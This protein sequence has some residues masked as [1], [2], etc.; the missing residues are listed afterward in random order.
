[1]RIFHSKKQLA[2]FFMPGF[3]LGIIYMNF[4]ADKYMAEPGI[5]NEYFLNQF[6]T[7]YIDAK[8]YIWY[9]LK[10]RVLPIVILYALSNTRASKLSA[11]LYVLW[12]GITG[13]ILVTSAVDSLGLKGS[14][15]CMTG[16]FPQFAFY[17]PA[18]M[19]LLWYCY[20]APGNS[21]NRQ[22]TIFVILCMAVGI[23]SELYINPVFVKAFLSVL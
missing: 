6:Q 17:I 22:K 21:W 7:V 11:V 18:Y 13:G 16:L 3:V 9:L 10:V 20:N 8:E 23:I 4:I 12:T 5:F 14:F 2:A 19:I 1:M 15:L